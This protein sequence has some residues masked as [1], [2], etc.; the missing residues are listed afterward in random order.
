MSTI[1]RSYAS[2]SRARTSASRGDADELARD[3]AAAGPRRARREPA[4]GELRP[5]AVARSRSHSVAVLGGAVPDQDRCAG[6]RARASTLPSRTSVTPSAEVSRKNRSRYGLRRSRSTSATLLP[7]RASTTA[8][9][10]AVVDLPSFSSGARHDDRAHVAAAHAHELEIRAQQA[11]RLGDV[12]LRLRD[13]R[14][15]VALLHLP[16]RRREAREQRQ[17]AEQLT[18]LARRPD[19]RVERLHAEGETEAEQQAENEADRG[20]S[21]RMR[22]DLDAE[23]GAANRRSHPTSAAS[24]ASAAV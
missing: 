20:I 4:L 17:P 12:V 15:L 10:A 1:T 5:V 11:K 14:E 13:H 6:A 19:P 8:R 3:P 23:L 9:F 18:E 16:R 7:E 24:A 21:P 22:R 2:R